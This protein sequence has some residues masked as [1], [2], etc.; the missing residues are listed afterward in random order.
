[1]ILCILSTFQHTRQII[2]TPSDIY[3]YI[4]IYI[5]IHIAW[6]IISYAQEKNKKN[7][8]CPMK[9]KSNFLSSDVTSI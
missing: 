9:M 3:I 2:C 4:Y 7:K 1:M 8:K 6:D 5:Y